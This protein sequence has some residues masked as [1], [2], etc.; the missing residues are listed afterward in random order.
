MFFLYFPKIMPYPS[1]RFLLIII[2]VHFQLNLVINFIEF[3]FFAHKCSIFHLA[4]LA[5]H[6]VFLKAFLFVRFVTFRYINFIKLIPFHSLFAP[7]NLF[8]IKFLFKI[9]L[10]FVL[11]FRYLPLRLPFNQPKLK[12]INFIHLIIAI[13]VHFFTQKLNFQHMWLKV[14][15]LVHYFLTKIAKFSQ[16]HPLLTLLVNFILNYFKK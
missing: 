3:L 16:K 11:V 12:F 6:F 5:F 10:F 2:F 15:F 4:F 13:K 14:G 7:V 1:V 8:G 9:N